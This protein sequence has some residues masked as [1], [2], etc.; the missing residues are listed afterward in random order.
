MNNIHY[1]GTKL[2]EN[3]ILTNGKTVY[4]YDPSE[5]LKEAVKLMMLLRKP[6][7]IMGEPGCGKT[8][9]AEAVAFELYEDAAF[10][11][12]SPLYFE[13]NIKSNSKVSEGLYRYDAIKRLNDSQVFK[14]KEDRAKL[15]NMKLDAEDSYIQAGILA[16]AFKASTK[17]KPSIILIDEIDKA[18]IDF[19][20]DLLLEIEKF[21]FTIPE[22]GEKI[23]SP[24][25][26]PLI[27]ITSNQ[28]R[29][30]PPAFLRRCIYLYIDFPEKAQLE[31]IVS[32]RFNDVET[33]LAKKAVETFIQLRQ[34]MDNRNANAE[35]KISTSE[36]LDW[37]EVMNEML[38]IQNPNEEEQTLIQKITVWKENPKGKIPFY[39]VLLKGVESIQLFKDQI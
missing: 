20:N 27:F 8:R 32:H 23:P 21:T 15:N 9:L 11:E 19:P 5:R 4:A 17:G 33:E 3:V 24:E 6:L 34:K 31:T 2:T 13:W 35:K 29:E 7:L 36:L 30:L 14:D 39:Q 28:E 16:K 25:E 26:A 12:E 1:A 37:I 38:K 18:D 22:T 10:S